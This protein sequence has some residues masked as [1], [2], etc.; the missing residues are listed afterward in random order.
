MNTISP[1]PADATGDDSTGAPDDGAP[2]APVSRCSDPWWHPSGM[3]DRTA[4]T[5]RS[6]EKHL[7]R[8]PVA[9]LTTA[10][11][12]TARWITENVR[13]RAEETLPG[14]PRA[15]MTASMI[16]HVAMDESIMAM[17]VGPNRFPSRS[18]YQRVGAELALAH[19]RMSARG[20]L[21][22]PVSYHV[23][24]PALENPAMSTGWALGRSYERLWWPSGYEPPDGMPGRD[25]W[26]A[27]EANR[28]ASAWILRHRD[29]PRPWVLCIHGFGTG[30][31][32]MDLFGF[33]AGH[34]HDDLGL[35][36][37]AIV[38]PV[39]GSRK[40]SRL[41]GEEFLGFDMM[42]GVHGLSQAVW[43]VR[44][45][46]SW[47]RAQDPT[48]VGLFGVS[49][50]GYTTALVSA[51]E[52]D[53]DMVLA[54]IP[55]SDFVELFRYHS[56]H[57]VHLRAIEHRI[58]DGTAED[59]YRVVSPLAMPTVTPHAA[60]AMFAG[61]GD[62]LAPPE[63]AHGLW[64]HWEDPETCWFP[65]NHV[66]YLWSDKVWRFVDAACSSRGLITEP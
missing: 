4:A 43:D 60:R 37:A 29:R 32:F 3:L 45:L 24:P 15:R 52:P 31:V 55:V 59:V 30:S 27:F 61:L 47:I 13:H 51:V 16:G 12:R 20:W 38:L 62:R 14:M 65:G 53:L 2:P 33:R 46:L 5:W 66:G 50:G 19:D 57:H 9:R 64:Q 18:D 35:N 22:D 44:S 28:T 40:P 23:A 49:L 11:P 7:A 17:A 6:V 21:E 58:L 8:Q 42:N 63:Q 1:A 25:R 36:V 34:L 39:H 48:G 41:S 10:G 56:P 26:Q 54:G